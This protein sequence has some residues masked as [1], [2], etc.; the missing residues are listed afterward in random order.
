MIEFKKKADIAGERLLRGL[1]GA[2]E[3]VI[4]LYQKRD[5]GDIQ[6][7]LLWLLKNQKPKVV[8]KWL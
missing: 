1:P 8:N 7:S 5:K 2:L 6:I 4:D 3:E